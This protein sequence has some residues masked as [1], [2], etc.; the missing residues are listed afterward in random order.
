MGSLYGVVNDIVNAQTKEEAERI[1]YGENGIRIDT[2][3]YY[4][5]IITNFMKKR[6][7]IIQKDQNGNLIFDLEN[8]NA[9]YNILFMYVYINGKWEDNLKSII[10]Q[11][12]II[13]DKIIIISQ[14]KEIEEEILKKIK[15]EK[16]IDSKN[17]KKI[18]LQSKKIVDYYVDVDS[19]NFDS[20]KINKSKVKN[21]KD[22]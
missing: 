8:I 9:L 2:S 1:F 12:K 16:G 15:T 5:S 10:D 4:Q 7:L 17:I 22:I 3:K 13:N 19:N 14:I 21:K 11:T 18:E 20:I 6:E